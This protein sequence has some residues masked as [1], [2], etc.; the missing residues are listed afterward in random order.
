VELASAFAHVLGPYPIVAYPEDVG[1][2]HD[3]ARP[4]TKDADN[5]GLDRAIAAP[6]PAPESASSPTPEPT[7]TTPTPRGR[8]ASIPVLDVVLDPGAASRKEPGPKATRALSPERTA[9]YGALAGLLLMI[10][11][12]AVLITKSGGRVGALTRSFVREATS[13]AP[14]PSAAPPASASA[15]PLPPS[16]PSAPAIPAGRP[17]PGPWRISQIAASPDVKVVEGSPDRRALVEALTSSGV[18]R[19]QIYRLLSAFQGVRKFDKL[20]RKD[21]YTVALELPTRRVRAFEY[22]V[23]PTEIYQAKENENGVLVGERLDLH[24]EKKRATGALVVGDDLASSLQAAGF[25]PSLVDLLDDALEGRAQL[26]SLRAGSRLRIV[27][28]Y[29]TALGVFAHYLDVLAIEVTP[30]DPDASALRVYRFHSD[31]AQGYFD[32]RG[33]QPYKGGFRSPIPFARISSRFNLRRMHP[34]LHVIKPHNGVDFVAST[35]TPVY[36]AS[37]GNIEWIGDSGPSG[38]L[39]TIRHAN[40]ITTGYAH[41]SRFAPNLSRGE[42]VDT[43]QLV[44]YVGSTGRST[45]PHLHFSAKRNGVFIDPLALKLDGDRVLPKSE[46]PT[47]EEQRAALDKLLEAILLPPAPEVIRAKQDVEGEDLEPL[48]D[49]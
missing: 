42:P 17:I 36:A 7:P 12:F 2:S 37:G 40:G 30:A 35:G 33:H 38:N 41:L 47:F 26:S 20:K 48:E 43:R 44:G 6:S 31:K 27:T 45:G 21:T 5:I 10:A 1:G 24:V 29:E 46:R 14:S 39:V 18:P 22:Q 23:S 25:E 16:G 15:A 4:T 49:H 9:I 13:E 11:I 32:G 3:E 8:I 19:A 34:I 28:D